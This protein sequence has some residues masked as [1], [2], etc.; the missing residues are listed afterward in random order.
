MK[1]YVKLFKDVQEQKGKGSKERKVELMTAHKTDKTLIE[2][3]LVAFNDNV[4]T[5][6][7]KAKL[8]KPVKLAPNIVIDCIVGLL[9][10]VQMH[11]TGTDQDIAN[12]Q[13]YLAKLEDDE[14]ELVSKIIT[15]ELKIGLSKEL[16]DIFEMEIVVILLAQKGFNVKDYYDKV[17]DEDITATVKEDGNRCTFENGKFMSYNRKEYKG[18]NELYKECIEHLPKNMVFDGELKFIDTTGKMTR[19]QIKKRTDEILNSDMEDK[20]DIKFVLFDCIQNGNFKVD[21]IEETPFKTRRKLLANL[22]KTVQSNGSKLIS[23]VEILFTSKGLVEVGKWLQYC[24][25]NDYEG[26]MIN[27]DNAPYECR[28]AYNIFKVKLI[29]TYDLEV[30]GVYEGE[31]DLTG[32]LGGLHCSYKGNIVN[33]GGGYSREL[34]DFYWANPSDV[35]GKIIEVESFGET[36]NK[37]TGLNSL[38]NPIF[39][40]E[41]L[42]KN[43]GE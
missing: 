9:H 27:I 1:K 26:F 38:M 41:R 12:I 32:S 14:K 15:K 35:I 36:T 20:K 37:K 42:D 25:D 8:N 16:N 29:D 4:K 31:N 7:K 43:E 3:L 5:G 23:I 30:T 2:I 6:L 10:Y 34:R 22:V 17:E 13:Y 28:R 24:K 11:F 33:V 19:N 40:R 21:G 39:I 18:L